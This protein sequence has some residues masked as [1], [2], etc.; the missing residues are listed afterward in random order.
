MDNQITFLS[1]SFI[2]S[3]LY[4]SSSFILLFQWLEPPSEQCDTIVV[5]EAICASSFHGIGGNGTLIFKGLYSC[6]IGMF[7]VRPS[8]FVVRKNMYLK[9]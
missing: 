1:V 2:L 5:T 7:R 9:E 4:D 8:K 6:I 3:N